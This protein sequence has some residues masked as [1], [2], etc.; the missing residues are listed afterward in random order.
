MSML[1]DITGL[2]SYVSSQI[3]AVILIICF[4]CLARAFI[5]QRWGMFFSNLIFAI[6]CW[7]VVANPGQ[8]ETLAKGVWNIVAHGGLH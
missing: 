2:T 5:S 7:V 8:F 1:P 4:I 6:V 3:A